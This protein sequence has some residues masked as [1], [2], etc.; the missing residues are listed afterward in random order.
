MLNQPKFAVHQ[1]TTK[2]F[3]Q[4]WRHLKGNYDLNSAFEN[5]DELLDQK[6]TDSQSPYIAPQTF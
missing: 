3:Q 1:Q 6:C 2:L 5:A 4:H